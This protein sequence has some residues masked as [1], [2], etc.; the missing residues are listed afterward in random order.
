[1]KF[2]FITLTFTIL[3]TGCSQNAFTKFNLDKEQELSVSSSQTSKITFSNSNKVYGIFSAVYLNEINPKS[4]NKNEYFYIYVYLK[5]ETSSKKSFLMKNIDSSITL[6]GR[7]P[8]KIE[9]LPHANRFSHLSVVSNKWNK[10]YLFTFKKEDNVTKQLKLTFKK[11]DL[12]SEV[13]T[14]K[15]YIR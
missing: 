2:F 8:I 6:N 10:Y 11:D 9:K 3:L 5:N 4:F 12:S 15:K 7:P 13:L 14:Y 1:M